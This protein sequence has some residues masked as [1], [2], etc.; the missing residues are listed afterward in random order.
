MANAHFKIKKPQ[1][2]A[3]KYAQLGINIQFFQGTQTHVTNI[4]IRNAG[5]KTSM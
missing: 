4:I 2:F 3:T 5:Y 1:S